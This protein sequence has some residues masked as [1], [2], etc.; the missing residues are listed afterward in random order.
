MQF[1]VKHKR[2]FWYSI[3]LKKK[4]FRE[5]V[6]QHAWPRQ[7]RDTSLQPSRSQV[8]PIDE[9][10]GLYLQESGPP[11]G[12]LSRLLWTPRLAWDE[13]SPDLLLLSLPTVEGYLA[14]AKLAG[15]CS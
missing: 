2:I 12:D 1:S 9:S 4:P 5:A 11:K 10:Y 13:S 7:V 6:T 15:S 8:S 14:L 3:H